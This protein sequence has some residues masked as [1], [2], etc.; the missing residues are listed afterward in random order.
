M[1]GLEDEAVGIEAVRKGAQDYLVKGQTQPHMLVRAIHYAIERKR[2]DEALE[3]ARIEA[4][5]EKNR[6]EAVMESLPVGMAILDSQGGNIRSNGMFEKVWGGPPPETHE[7]SDYAHYKAWWVDTGKPV[8]PEQW[9]SARAVQKGETVV[10][11]LIEI[12][13][14]DG[15]RAFV[16]NSA[17]PI[18]DA[19][20]K[21][22]GSA[23]A[24]LDIT[25]RIKAEEELRQKEAELRDAQRVA[26]VGSWYWDAKTDITTGSD[27]LLR[28][29]GLDPTTQHMPRFRDQDGRLYPHESWQQV[30]AAVQETLQTGV[31]YELEVRAIC[32]GAPIWISTRSEVVRDADGQILGL[33]GTVQDISDRKCAEEEIRSLAEFPKENPNPIIRAS[34]D[35]PVL[36]A[37]Q[38]AIALLEAM[39]WHAGQSLPEELLRQARLV[40]EGGGK[41]DFDLLCPA[42]RTFSFTVAPSSRAGQVNFYARDITDRKQAEEAL[43]QNKER[44]QRLIKLAPI[45]LC[46][47]NKNGELSY[48]NDRFIQ[49]FGYTHDDVPTLN[50]W[51]QLAYPDEQYRRW[52]V[53][54]WESAVRRASETNTDIEPIEYNVTCKDG[55]VRVVVISG[56]T[57]EDDFL[58]TFIDITE[59]K[60][61]ES[62]LQTTLQRFYNVLSSMYSGILLVT[63][64]ERIEFA[65]QAF[66]D[67]FG[68]ED[69]PTDLVGFDSRVI[70]EKIKNA[71]LHP[72]EA[73]ARIREVLDRGQ[74]VKGEELTMQSGRTCLRDFVPLN[75]HGKSYGR[76]WLHIDITDR[77]RAEEAMAAAKAAAEEANQ[78]KSRFLANISHELR[79]PMNAILGMIDLASQKAIDPTARDFLNIARQSADLLLTLL[80][81]LLDCSK[82][83]AGKL[84]LESAPFSLRRM[85]DQ[86]ARVLA[87][88]ASEKGLVFSC[89]IP[90]GTPDA[91]VGDQ[92]RLRQILFNLAGNAVKFTERGEVEVSV[93]AESQDTEEACLEFAVRDTGIGISS[94][95][96][97]RIFHPFSQA[98]VSTTRQF[99]GTGL[100]LS[101]CSSLVGIMGGRI[102]AESELGKGSIFHFTVKLP[103]AKELPAEPEALPSL[104]AVKASTLRILLAEDNPANQKLAAYILRD[105]GH[106][107]EIAGDGRQALRM[108]EENQYD[109]IMMDVQMPG[110]DGLE[111]T[112]AIRAGEK[113]KRRMPIIAMTAYAM[114][115]DRE[116]FLRPEWTATCPSPPTPRKCLPWWRVWPPGRQR[117]TLPRT[118]QLPARKNS[119]ILRPPLSSIPSWR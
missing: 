118:R 61:A 44:Y 95:D 11:Q 27:E 79:T 75:I 72:D 81:D 36:Y 47:V 52:V 4:L 87:V 33:R 65:N 64:E 117:P 78:A 31:G 3:A 22:T 5:N 99:G 119:R 83:E 96:L 102:W 111:A 40:L 63:D 74:P 106:T 59:R 13:R 108:A 107:V 69:A 91:L 88:R 7:I 77:K 42:G 24:I 80:N 2:M 66:C 9:A 53:E 21:L 60:R 112:A 113:G 84:E 109:V 46:F 57:I 71:Y 51:W 86:L 62:A 115:G 70:I 34:G 37:N 73:V 43:R 82:I 25:D 67:S 49:M 19:D 97:E 114:K 32:N 58:A 20:G 89:H 98:D 6:L 17:T 30:N 54:T 93:R 68:L 104:P 23:V 90:A 26:H 15:K 38:P 56:I 76:L 14:F 48:F 29:Y 94:S 100:G 10:G 8:L 101:I 12:E 110:M 55:T 35:G 45:P 105:R 41:R 50:E 92:V 116:R 28:I 39:G 18:L 16:I 103:L 1:T 85:L